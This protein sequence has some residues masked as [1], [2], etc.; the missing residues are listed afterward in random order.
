MGTTSD[1]VQTDDVLID[2]VLIDDDPR[3][4]VQSFVSNY[5]THVHP[6]FTLREAARVMRDDD[7][8]LAIV[9]DADMVVGVISERDVV[10]AVGAGLDVDRS[11]VAQVETDDLLWTSVTTPIDDA[12]ELMVQRNV[13]HLLIGDGLDDLVGVV[14]MRD[15]ITAFLV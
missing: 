7:V 9:S 10:G 13:R 8:G 1:H 4:T 5:I 2:D 11:T 6:T 15:L 14:S 12:A 3:R